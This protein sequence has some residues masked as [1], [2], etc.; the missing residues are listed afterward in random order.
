M[1]VIDIKLTYDIYELILQRQSLPKSIE[2][3]VQT[4]LSNY[5][6]VMV[7]GSPTSTGRWVKSMLGHKFVCFVNSDT[8]D[9]DMHVEF[10]AFMLGTSPQHYTKIM[11]VLSTLKTE[12]TIIKPFILPDIEKERAIRLHQDRLILENFM[13]NF[14]WLKSQTDI[15]EHL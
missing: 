7:Y 15:E 4:K 1:N 5:S 13:K 3:Q 10:D 9:N 8:F 12:C 14:G 6:H 2:Q 11:E